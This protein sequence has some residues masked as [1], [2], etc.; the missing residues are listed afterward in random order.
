MKPL[1]LG[2]ICLAYIL[3][4]LDLIPD[5]IPILGRFDDVLA[6]V[7]TAILLYRRKARDARARSQ[8]GGSVPPP[9]ALSLEPHQVL[10]VERGAG[11]EEI[12][13]AYRELLAQY[14]PDKVAHLGP[15]LRETAHRKTLE[16]R[17]AYE[18]LCP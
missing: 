11:P 15:E 1:V 13:R 4:P 9:A 16:I 10:G 14:H 5:L 8:S 2:G 6:L 17:K 3:F 12:R 18:T 7:V